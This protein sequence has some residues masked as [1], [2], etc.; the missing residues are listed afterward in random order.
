MFKF[1]VTKIFTWVIL[2]LVMMIT[3]NGF[4]ISREFGKQLDAFMEYH[5]SE[6][7][8]HATLE[9]RMMHLQEDMHKLT[10]SIITHNSTH[11]EHKVVDK[12]TK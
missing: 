10:E 4:L 2:V 5:K 3:F 9:T 1:E 6:V 7:A 8:R 12:K 11:K